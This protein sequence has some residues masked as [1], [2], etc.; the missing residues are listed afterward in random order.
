MA[1]SDI[2]KWLDFRILILLIRVFL[3]AS[4]SSQNMKLTLAYW[5]VQLIALIQ[6]FL[7]VYVT[8][9]QNQR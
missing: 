7:K 1:R 5:S 9:W 4:Q 8:V 6:G 3:F 2:L